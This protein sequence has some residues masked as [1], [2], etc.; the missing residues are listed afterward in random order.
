MEVNEPT[1]RRN[2]VK[3]PIMAPN[4]P[5]LA[6]IMPI[7]TQ[8]RCLVSIRQLPLYFRLTASGTFKPGSSGDKGACRSFDTI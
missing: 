4:I 5:A 2:K 3:D 8:C 1:I 7:F 6:L